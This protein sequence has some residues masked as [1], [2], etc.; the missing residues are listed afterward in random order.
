MNFN[1]PAKI[2]NKKGTLRK[3]GYEFEF[4]GIELRNVAEIIMQLFGGNHRE[5]NRFYHE[6]EQT[7]IGD[8]KIEMDSTL[9]KDESYISALKKI[10]IDLSEHPLQEPLEDLLKNVASV[11]VPCEIAVPPVAIT[12]MDSI[13]KLRSALQTQHIEGTRTSF[14]N[15]FGLH[16]NIEMPEQTA[17]TVLNY[18]RSFFL[19]YEWIFKES[20]ID[21]SRRIPPFINEFPSDYILLVLD[22][23]YKPDLKILIRDYMKYNPTRNRALDLFPIFAL[24]D[25]NYFESFIRDEKNTARPAFHYRLP[26]CLVDESDWRIATEWN[27]WVEVEKLADNLLEISKLSEEYIH[28]WD[29]TFINFKS[30]W[31][32]I[33]KN[34][35]KTGE[36]V[37]R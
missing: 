11:V 25:E 12:E 14:V 19:L 28:V 2:K 8:F 35:K 17:N 9:L 24:M 4:S 10:G 34:W 22:P 13:E 3:I 30:K 6:V 36:I 29:T 31:Y 33:I 1:L 26:N 5:V 18:L 20:N 32:Q 16:I 21:F 15:A 7:S 23:L 27:L 37:D